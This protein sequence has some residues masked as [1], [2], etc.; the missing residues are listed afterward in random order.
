MNVH[1]KD[2]C[3][4]YL[5]I[6][7]LV[8]ILNTIYRRGQSVN[9]IEVR[10]KD[11]VMDILFAPITFPI[12]LVGHIISILGMWGT[13]ILIVISIFVFG[14]YPTFAAIGFIIV[15]YILL[16]ILALIFD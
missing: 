3:M 16:A 11:A 8:M 7:Y 15:C 4:I 1:L 6:S 12:L 14:L 5:L 9:G 10:N 13:G 2:E